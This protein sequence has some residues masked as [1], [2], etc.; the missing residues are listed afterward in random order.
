M[1]G[2]GSVRTVE[3]KK[4]LKKPLMRRSKA[5]HSSH[6]RLL[7]CLFAL[8]RQILKGYKTKQLFFP[9]AFGI[10]GLLII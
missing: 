7:C 5:F 8:D 2:R 3:A 10:K 1:K 6:C 9:L 4:P